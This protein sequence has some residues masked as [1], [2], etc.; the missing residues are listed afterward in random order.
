ML[1]KTPITEF[2]TTKIKNIHFKECQYWVNK[3]VE[4]GKQKREERRV[5][6]NG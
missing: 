1:L 3:T 4:K 6:D 5:L 2:K